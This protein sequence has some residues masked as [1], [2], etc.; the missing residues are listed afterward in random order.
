MGNASKLPWGQKAKKAKDAGSE[1][2]VLERKLAM[3]KKPAPPDPHEALLDWMVFSY[4]QFST[5]DE[6]E[7]KELLALA[8]KNQITAGN[9]VLRVFI[10]KAA[11]A[12]VGDK[13]KKKYCAIFEKAL[14][15]DLHHW[16][17]RKFIRD[18]GGITRCANGTKPAKPLGLN[19]FRT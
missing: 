1:L 6:D 7:L 5:L 4:G 15:K 13:Q 19:P 8:K 10:K 16:G 14:A 3:I 12:H 17:L 11:A 9:V 18:N 2:S